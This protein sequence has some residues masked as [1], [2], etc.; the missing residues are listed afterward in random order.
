M[1]RRVASAN[2]DLKVRTGNNRRPGLWCCRST[3]ETGSTHPAKSRRSAPYDPL[4]I[5]L[6]LTGA[7]FFVQAS[8]PRKQSRCAST[9]PR[10]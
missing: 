2:K 1:T 5:G 7:N 3:R 4:I 8:P 6:A 9:S 10:V